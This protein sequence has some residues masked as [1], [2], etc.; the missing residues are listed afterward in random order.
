MLCAVKARRNRFCVRVVWWS[1]YLSGLL[2][3]ERRAHIINTRFWEEAGGDVLSVV[4][5]N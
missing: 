4:M 2:W 1:D 5:M 3:T